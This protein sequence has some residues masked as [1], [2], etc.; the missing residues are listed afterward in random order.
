MN[1][2]ASSQGSKICFGY[3]GIIFNGDKV[4]KKFSKISQLYK[5][6]G[7]SK[8]VYKLY[9]KTGKMDRG[10]FPNL[11]PRPSP[12]PSLSPSLSYI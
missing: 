2:S 11:S 7:G 6:R 5:T 1:F 8:A 10:G 9:K 12:S 3:Q 4:V